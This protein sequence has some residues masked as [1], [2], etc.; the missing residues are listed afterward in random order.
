MKKTLKGKIVAGL[1]A[2]AVS[3]TTPG[4]P[5]AVQ[6]V[7]AEGMELPSE[8]NTSF[9]KAR[10]LAFGA[11]MAGTLS[12][13]DSNRYY[14]FSLDEASRL[15]L[16]IECNYWLD[17]TIYDATQTEVYNIRGLRTFSVEEIYLTGGDYY[18]RLYYNYDNTPFSFIANMDSMGESFTETQDYNNDMSSDASSISLKK[19]YKGV[20]AQNDDIDYYKFQSPAAGQIT[21]NITN[22][23]SDT[24]KY[25]VYDESL[26]PAYTNTVRR[27][28]KVTQPVSVKSGSYYLA[29]AKENVNKGTGSYTFSIDHK[30]KISAAPKLKSVKNASSGR[31]AVTWSQVAGASGYELWY[32][33][34]PNFKGAVEKKEL[35]ASSS[36][37][38]Y[39]GLT[40]KKT[41]YVKIRAY[42]EINGV[43]DYGKWSGKKSVKIKK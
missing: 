16:G 4:L 14:K 2:L 41:Y 23:T 12:P 3:V 7:H 11:S 25:G 17:I 36:S 35:S 31:M 24:V 29:I 42:E 30:K 26:N 13:N 34:D 20:L 6:A 39:Y 40:R 37:A 38:E 28:E 9:S 21:L 33:T 43:K 18:M 10:E 19:K 1:A 32:S 5:M 22:S 8:T 27:G 15:N